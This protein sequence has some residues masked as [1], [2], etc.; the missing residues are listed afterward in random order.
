MN[1]DPIKK[2]GNKRKKGFDPADLDL[3]LSPP[4]NTPQDPEL[5]TRT[6]WVDAKTAL[7]E[8]NKVKSDLVPPSGSPP[9][10]PL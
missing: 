3:E 10:P 6:A 8:I 2:K 7:N 4:I 9:P 5:L 1:T